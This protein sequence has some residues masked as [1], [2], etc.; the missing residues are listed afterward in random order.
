MS[1][2]IAA[3]AAPEGRALLEGLPEGAIPDNVST[4]RDTEEENDLL[5]MSPPELKALRKSSKRNHTN[6]LKRMAV[7]IA[8]KGSRREL[9]RLENELLTFMHECLRYNNALLQVAQ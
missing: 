6:L 7:L 3:T 5:S 9:R 8:N 1:T 4:V 2:V